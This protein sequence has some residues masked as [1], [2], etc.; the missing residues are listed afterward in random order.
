MGP[1]TEREW[2]EEERDKNKEAQLER[3][4]NRKKKQSRGRK[5]LSHSDRVNCDFLTECL[6]RL[7]AEMLN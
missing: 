3:Q 7:R 1:T 4:R 5:D 6:M 2:R